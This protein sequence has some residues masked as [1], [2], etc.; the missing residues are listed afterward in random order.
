ML[1]CLRR[2][3]LASCMGLSLGLG[4]AQALE[5]PCAL[6][7]RWDLLQQVELPRRDPDGAP[8]GGLS[9]ASFDPASGELWLLSD[10]N[11]GSVVVWS[12]LTAPGGGTAPGQLRRILPLRHAPIDGEGLVRLNGQLWVASEGRIAPRRPAQLLRFDAGSGRLLQSVDLPPDW[13]PALNQ[14][15]ASNGGPESL[16][17]VRQPDGRP[18][19]LMAAEQ[20]LQQDPPRS[21]RLL[22]WHW[23]RDQD[24]SLTA[25]TPVHQGALLLPDGDQWGLTDLMVVQPSGQLLGLLRRF[26]FPNQW[27]IRLALYPLPDPNASKPAPPLAEWDLISAGLEPDNWE[28]ITTGPPLGLGRPVL[29]MISDDNLNPLQANRMAMLTPRCS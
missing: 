20:P 27:Q 10:L 8:I 14:G 22:R 7:S 19:L 17:L 4:S 9:A 23:R 26:Q 25:P 1:S 18:A 24:P 29:L 11:P 6:P 5:L 28:G 3:A 12:G 13:Q 2:A 21:V 15:L 16:V